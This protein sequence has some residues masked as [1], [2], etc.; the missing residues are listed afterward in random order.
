MEALRKIVP[1]SA[2]EP[3]FSLPRSSREL[4]YEVLILPIFEESA[5]GFAPP[6]ARRKKTVDITQF[7]GT[8]P[9][10][11][12]SDIREEEDREL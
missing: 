7:F 4:Q 11:D 6:P 8:L 9:H 2:L 1:G 12:T 10:L 5:P 3:L